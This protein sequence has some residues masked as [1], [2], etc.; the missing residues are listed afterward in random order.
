MYKALIVANNQN[1]KSWDSKIKDVY[2][3]FNGLIEI[4]IVHTEFKNVPFTKFADDKYEID[5]DW[6][7]T[8][9]HPLCGDYD[10]VIFSLPTK[11]WKGQGITGRWTHDS[12]IEEI[13]IGADEKGEYYFGSKKFPGDRWFHLARHEL[14]HALYKI[15][16][17]YDMTHFWWELGAFELS[18]DELLAISKSKK[19]TTWKYFKDKEVVGLKKELVDMLDLARGIAGIPFVINSGYRSV[20]KNDE[21]GGVEGSSHIKG[22]AAD[23]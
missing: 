16:G 22:F 23:I 2:D 13:Q 17:A 8:N 9:I 4:D 19:P 14:S 5:R 20:E 10:I 1:W 15:L 18:R 11:Q 21:V 12:R 3:W 6:Y 7:D